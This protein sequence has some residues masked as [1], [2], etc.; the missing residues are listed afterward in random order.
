MSSRAIYSRAGLPAAA[1][2]AFGFLGAGSLGAQAVS[3]KINLPKDSPV[4]VVSMDWSQSRATPRGGAYLVDVHASLSLRNSSSK[5]IRGV[6]LAVLAQEVTP[7]GKGAV[8]VP[9]LNVA[10]GDAF[11]VRIDLPLLRPIGTSQS[12]A[13][14]VEVRLD[15]V[16]FDDLSFYGPDNLHSQRNM[17]VWEL[18]ARRDRKYFKNLLETG[19]PKALQHE[20]LDSLARQADLPRPGV[21][22]VRGRSTNTDPEHQLQFAFLAVPDA[23]VEPA[24]GTAQIT[25][26][27]ASQP[28]FEVRNRSKRPVQFLE[29]GWI[30]RDQRGNQFLAASLP[31]EV[32]LAPGQSGEVAQDAA[33]RF[34][35]R[36]SIQSMSG[37]V[38]QVQFADGSYWIPSRKVLE[39]LHLN[40]IVAPSPEEQ[41]LSHI[42]SKKGL[43]ALVEELKKF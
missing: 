16:L 28:R 32:N 30:V 20:M 13:P 14:T 29:I 8:S 26:N 34:S 18:E 41:R 5:R 11:P 7:G 36:T 17:T 21:Q 35:P 40:T 3:P 23:P 37:F 6:T 4:A 33:L 12:S 19:G 31:A 15:G 43:D 22:M 1:L 9:S 2:L 27:E 24:S 25:A 42:Y 38:S 10:P 39:Q